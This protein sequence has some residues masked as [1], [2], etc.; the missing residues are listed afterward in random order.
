M[1]NITQAF[2]RTD[3]VIRNLPYLPKVLLPVDQYA[4]HSE[5][6]PKNYKSIRNFAKTVFSAIVPSYSPFREVP[7]LP[8]ALPEQG[9]PI[10]DNQAW[11][12]LNGIC[13]DKNVLQLNGKA[14]A[15]LFQRK[16]YLM[17]NPS[18]GIVLDLLECVVGRTIQP[19][20]SLDS[21]VAA[22]LEDALNTHQKVI[23][24]AHSQ[25]GIIATGALY[26][27]VE[28]L[29][30]S[31]SRLFK[32]LEVYTFASAA[33]EFKLPQI[34]AE[35][36]WHKDDYV[37]RIGISGNNRKFTGRKFNYTASGHLLNT[38]YL[39]NFIE[40]KFIGTDRKASEL[41]KKLNLTSTPNNKVHAM[42]NK[43]TIAK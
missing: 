9:T 33:T 21:S 37:A 32:K 34:Y 15:N 29:T 17:H 36:F 25:G 30:G 26:K 10:E 12:F 7:H 23:L 31:R 8:Y 3:L 14:L 27:L 11:F 5:L 42:G 6:N 1:M 38:H 2:K 28:T 24:F 4:P 20:T 18:D 41:I 16:V 13:T 43:V 22:I 40:N 39:K 19:A 35:H